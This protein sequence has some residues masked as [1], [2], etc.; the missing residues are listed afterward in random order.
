[1]ASEEDLMEAL[2][3]MDDSGE[4]NDAEIM[5]R[6]DKFIFSR[7]PQGVPQKI[8]GKE[9]II[10]KQNIEDILNTAKALGSR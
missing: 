8:L 3:L 2:G 1:M 5:A 6:L 10:T 9:F 4:V 7:N